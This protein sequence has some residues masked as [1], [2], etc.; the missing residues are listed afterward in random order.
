MKATYTIEE[1][2]S[3]IKTTIQQT[4]SGYTEWLKK[5]AE[6]VYKDTKEIV[7]NSEMSLKPDA[8]SMMDNYIYPRL[9]DNGIN[10]F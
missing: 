10:F 5:E 8:G 7:P 2:E 6:I 1:V 4:V 9:K 3:L